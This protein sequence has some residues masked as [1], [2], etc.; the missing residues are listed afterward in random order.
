MGSCPGRALAC[1]QPV[2][3][4]GWESNGYGGRCPGFEILPLA[5]CVNMN[6][7]LSP[8]RPEFPDCTTAEQPLILYGNGEA[9]LG[10]SI[11]ATVQ[12]G[13]DQGEEKLA[14]PRP[15]PC[16][17]PVWGTCRAVSALRKG[18]LSPGTKSWPARPCTSW[19]HISPEDVPPR[20]PHGHL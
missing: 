20:C 12:R 15:P 18:H 7:Q 6:F 3:R 16:C 10:F 1:S 11:R 17:S 13:R 8:S 4:S 2:L 9:D 19:G 5:G 14:P